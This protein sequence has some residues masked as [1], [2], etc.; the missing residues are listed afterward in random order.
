MGDPRALRKKYST[1]AHMWQGTRIVDEGKLINEY[2]LKNRREVWRAEAEVKKLREQARAL[3]GQTDERAEARKNLL[4]QKLAKLGAMKKDGTLEDILAF[5]IRGIL[6]RRI[7]T[8]VHK[9][10]MASTPKEA[11]QLLIHGHIAFGGRRH[12]RPSTLVLSGEENTIVYIGPSRDPK[13]RK[14][15]TEAAPKEEKP[16]ETAVKEEVKEEKPAEEKK[17]EPKKEKK[18]EAKSEKPA[19][20]KKDGEEK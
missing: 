15:K 5:D 20:E 17:E 11:R 1:P 6:E 13:P 19:E 2:G 10:G 4:T 9:K 12:T 8:L 14:S 7:Q 16:A 18:E 3:I